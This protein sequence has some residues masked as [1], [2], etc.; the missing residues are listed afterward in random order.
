M[1]KIKPQ[2]AAE[3]ST[4][5]LEQPAKAP[6]ESKYSAADLASAAR[7]RFGVPPEVVQAALKV[8]QVEKA[9]I[10]EAK[11]IVKAFMGRK[12]KR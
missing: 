6:A 10:S 7:A 5:T 8:A 1:A 12:V 4:A 3:S 2:E 9:T 11:K